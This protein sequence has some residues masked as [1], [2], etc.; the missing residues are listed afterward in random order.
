VNDDVLMVTANQTLVL[1]D[2]D[3]RRATPIPETYKQAVLA[4]EGEDCELK[5]PA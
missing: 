3:E 2:L 5:V 1:V 4:F